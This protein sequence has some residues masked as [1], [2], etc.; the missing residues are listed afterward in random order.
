MSAPS[1]Q[2]R[3]IWPR[4]YVKS[5]RLLLRRLGRS[6]RP[7]V[8]TALTL[9]LF[10][11]MLGFQN[12]MG[13]K[14]QTESGV[15]S[16]PSE[17]GGTPGGTTGGGNSTNGGT[18]TGG[19]TGSMVDPLLPYRVNGRPF[20]KDANNGSNAPAV[21]SNAYFNPNNLQL[22]VKIGLGPEG[23]HKPVLVPPQGFS[24]TNAW[25]GLRLY[26]HAGMST[27]SPSVREIDSSLELQ[28]SRQPASAPV[29]IESIMPSQAN[30]SAG[31]GIVPFGFRADLNSFC[32]ATNGTVDFAL[33][34]RDRNADDTNPLASDLSNYLTGFSHFG[35][36]QTR[37]NNDFGSAPRVTVRF[38]NSCPRET[39]VRYPWTVLDDSTGSNFVLDQDDKFGSGLASFGDTL[40]VTASGDS[41]ANNSLSLSGA[42]YVYRRVG[43][44]WVFQRKFVPP[45][46]DVRLQVAAVADTGEMAL[47]SPAAVD[48]SNSAIRGRGAVWLYRRD[49]DVGGRASYSLINPLLPNPMNTFGSDFFGSALLFRGPYLFIGASGDSTDATAQGAVYVYS[50]SGTLLQKII[51]KTASGQGLPDGVAAGSSLAATIQASTGNIILAVGAPLVST[52]NSGPGSVFIFS[53]NASGGANPCVQVQRIED[54]VTQGGARA[55]ASVALDASANGTLHLIVGAPGVNDAHYYR[56]DFGANS[57]TKQNFGTRNNQP[58]SLAR[59]AGQARASYGSAVAIAFP[60]AVIGAPSAA[61]DFGDQGGA[62]NQGGLVYVVKVDR[63]GTLAYEGDYFQ[64]RPRLGRANSR[65]G[66]SILLRDQN[67]IIE[68]LI[69]AEFYRART[70]AGGDVTNGGSVFSIEVPAQMLGDL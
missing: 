62:F 48:P 25:N 37:N 27:G 65:F 12:C 64:L 53:C 17:V 43:A 21:W 5:R 13:F 51:P 33:R 44:D 69:G 23:G 55:G 29:V 1:A 45:R 35:P 58:V 14:V 61:M 2:R 28:T 42:A 20:Y 60:Y 38:E 6:A 36:G 19:T 49:A 47:G 8:V 11:L 46:R 30:Q 50:K 41:G 16:S 10:C 7:F 67:G 63:G 39:E 59:P 66:N 54:I 26:A 57:F 34:L 56:R 22:V 32:P 31:P 18:T 52:S 9:V 70:P 40:V 24:Y 68:A 4:L 15:A 3:S